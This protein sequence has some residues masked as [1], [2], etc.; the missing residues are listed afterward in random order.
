MKLKP[1]LNSIWFDWGCTIVYD[2]PFIMCMLDANDEFNSM[3]IE[4]IVIC[5]PYMKRLQVCDAPKR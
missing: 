4:T 1:A 3:V 2:T 5:P